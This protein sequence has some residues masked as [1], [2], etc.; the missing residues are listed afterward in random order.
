MS[1]DCKDCLQLIEERDAAID[2]ADKLAE[3]IGAFFRADVG[4][5]VAGLGCPGN[6]PWRNALDLLSPK[7]ST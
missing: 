2:A 4:E 6:N 5:H 1:D 3:A 7:T